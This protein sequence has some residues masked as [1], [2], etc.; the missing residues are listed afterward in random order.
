MLTQAP[1]GEGVTRSPRDGSCGDLVPGVKR[2]RGSPQPA[3]LS[4]EVHLEDAGMREQWVHLP[5]HTDAVPFL[6]WQNDYLNLPI[7]NWAIVLS[8][9]CRKVLKYIFHI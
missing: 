1:R 9:S 7:F 4:T 3:P 2:C 8:F 6:L 5:P